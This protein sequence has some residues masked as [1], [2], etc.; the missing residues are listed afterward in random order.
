[1]DTTA[2]PSK[3]NLRASITRK[4]EER[5]AETTAKIDPHRAKAR[6]LLKDVADGEI[7]DFEGTF[8][9][10]KDPPSTSPLNRTWR[11]LS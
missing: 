10:P 1:M 4:F 7:I 8:T 5:V 9:A 3:R 6:T 11:L 2:G